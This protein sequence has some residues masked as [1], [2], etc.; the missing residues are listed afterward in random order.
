[1]SVDFA[2]RREARRAHVLEADVIKLSAP[3]VIVKPDI[4]TKTT[5]RLLLTTCG[6]RMVI[7]IRH[8]PRIPHV[9]E[10]IVIKQALTT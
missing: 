1:M 3:I 8:V 7:A 10:A 2:T 5:S 4:A 6:V 9:S